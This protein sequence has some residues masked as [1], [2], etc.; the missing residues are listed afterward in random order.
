[1]GTMSL[2]SVQVTNKNTSRNGSPITSYT[3]VIGTCK[4]IYK[5]VYPKID[6]VTL[7]MILK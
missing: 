6:L 7:L 2:S 5:N 3:T 4:T 1:M